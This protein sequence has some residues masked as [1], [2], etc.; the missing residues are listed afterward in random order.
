[1][2]IF[3]AAARRPGAADCGDPIARG[4]LSPAAR[5]RV[6]D[7]LKRKIDAVGCASPSLAELAEV[8]HLSIHHFARAFRESEG[9]TPHA[10]VMARRFDH[11]LTA[12][13]RV[14]GRIDQIG[15]STGFA[16]SAHFVSAF[17]KHMGV[18]PGAVRDVVHM[19][20]R[21]R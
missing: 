12:L 19:Q 13:L 18:T 8:A 7:F 1:M 3:A 17:R 2:Q 6:R 10:F 20:E 16:S 15:E 4:G 21:I 9:Q 14:N 5:R 11:A